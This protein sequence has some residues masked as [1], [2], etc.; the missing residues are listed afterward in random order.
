MERRCAALLGV[1]T[2]A[3]LAASGSDGQVSQLIAPDGRAA[4]QFGNSV[5][6]NGNTIVVGVREGDVGANLGQG[7]AYVFERDEGGVGSWHFTKKLTASDGAAGDAF[8]SSV[9]VSGDWVVVGAIN[10]DAVGN[11]NQ[12]SVYVFG[13][14]AGGTGNWGQVRKL[15]VSDGAASDFLGV[16]VSVDGD[17]IVAGA[18]G[19]DVGGNEDQGA[20]HVF[21]RNA[22][23]SNNWGW[24]SKLTANDGGRNDSFGCAVSVSGDLM[25]V[26][27]RYHDVGANF[28]Q[29]AAYLYQRSV[30][31]TGSWG[32]IR[33]LTA[34]DG[35]TL[36]RFGFAVSV[37]GDVVV[38][39]A[40]WDDVGG[41]ADQGSAYVF[42]RNAGG[43]NRWAQVQH[44][45]ADD[46]AASDWFGYAASV[47]GDR[48]VVGAPHG[49]V[50]TNSQQGAAYAFGRHVG[51]ASH[52]GLIEKL[53]TGDGAPS[54][55]M[56]RSV[57]L[58]GGV[59]VA[60]VPGDDVGANPSQGS[61]WV[62]ELPRLNQLS[63]Q[64]MPV[65][66]LLRFVGS[67]GHT[68]AWQ[69][70]TNLVDWLTLGI[71]VVPQDGVLEWPDL[72]PPRPVAFYRTTSP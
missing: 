69:R 51:G 35:A 26:G 22:G 1:L 12:G 45:V 20:A 4:D 71:A 27:A 37:S 55:A 54:D 44:L 60:G 67:P 33:K 10:G 2:L 42:E 7:L 15:A 3:A 25:V 46:G 65:G 34:S 50:G 58:S 14:N 32:L 70:S 56:G 16:S 30:G 63:I 19:A 40:Y 66:L 57:A 61:A 17:V 62:F 9:S 52:W 39:G 28:D 6:A 29:G 5:A 47:S 23:G 53:I 64:R 43:E 21:E 11:P 13:R 72:A 68:W 38:V 36:D 31:G 59:L 24:V 48:I 18:S 41:N 8:G 49:S